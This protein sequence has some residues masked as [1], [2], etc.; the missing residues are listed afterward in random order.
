MKRS[1]TCIPACVVFGSLLLSAAHA[2]ETLKLGIIGLDTSHVIRFSE[3]LNDP[4]RKDR[5]PGAVIVAAYKGGSP[6]VPES[7]DRIEAFT[8]EATTKYHVELM[9]DIPALCARV[10]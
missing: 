2:Q 7:A 1:S 3:L 9:P 6:T 10:D 8:K 5:V 4:G